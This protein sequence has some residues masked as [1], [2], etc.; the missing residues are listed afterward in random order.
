MSLGEKDSF[1]FFS[2]LSREGSGKL[3][4]LLRLVLP[5]KQQTSLT[6]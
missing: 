6:I 5:G 4:P 2:F 3:N 1:L